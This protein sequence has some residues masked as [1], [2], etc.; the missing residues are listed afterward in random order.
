MSGKLKNIFYAGIRYLNT[1]TVSDE[2]LNWLNFAN[3]GMLHRGNVFCMDYAIKNLP[4]HKPVLEIGSFCGLSANVIAYLL[5][6]HNKNNSIISSD[7]WIFEGA[8]NGGNLGLSSISHQDYHEYVKSTFKRNVEF[9]SRENKPYTIEVFSDEFFELW[10]KNKTVK[11]VFGRDVQLGGN[12][13]FCYID[14]NHTYEF[15]K[16]DFENTDKNLDVGGYI[17]FDDSYDGQPF[18]LTKLMKEVKNNKNYKLVMKN[19]NYL[20]MKTS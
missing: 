7:K 5:A 15:A 2:Y 19:P 16:R 6:K 10:D 11:D 17:L 3:A 4:S 1:K 20:F 9:F 14:G 13:S 12:F 8:E 18:G